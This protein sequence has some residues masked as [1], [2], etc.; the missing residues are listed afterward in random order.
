LN[1]VLGH[2]RAVMQEGSYLPTASILDPR[3]FP[4][5]NH[6]WTILD[7]NINI[8]AT[9]G[10]F[11]VSK[12]G[13]I[14]TG[15]KQD[16]LNAR[17]IPSADLSYFV[18]NFW[19]EL[20]TIEDGIDWRLDYEA[21]L[22][23]LWTLLSLEFMNG[24]ISS[25]VTR[26]GRNRFMMDLLAHIGHNESFSYTDS[27]TTSA[28]RMNELFE[29]DGIETVTATLMGYIPRFR[30]SQAARFTEASRV[31]G[32]EKFRTLLKTTPPEILNSEEDLKSFLEKI[33]RIAAYNPASLNREECIFVVNTYLAQQEEELGEV[34][35]EIFASLR[36]C[37]PGEISPGMV[38]EVFNRDPS[39][40]YQQ[41]AKVKI[42]NWAVRI[43]ERKARPIG[44]LD[45][46]LPIERTTCAF[47]AEAITAALNETLG[48]ARA[49]T[50]G[51]FYL[52]A[53]SEVDPG[54]FPNRNHAWT[55]LDGNINICATHG[56]FDVSKVGKILTGGKQKFL[57]ARLIPTA[58]LSYFVSDFWKEL[59]T[60][61]EDIS[62][63]LDHHTKLGLLWTLLSLEFMNE[64]I[65]SYVAIYGRNR[66]VMNLL[67]HIGYNESFSHAD[68]LK[69]SAVR[70]NEL[71]KSDGIETV[72]ATLM[73]YIPGFRENQAARFTE[74]NLLQ[75][76]KR[77]FHGMVGG[78]L[79]EDIG[80]L[81]NEK[82]SEVA[83]VLQ[84]TDGNIFRVFKRTGTQGI[85]GLHPSRVIKVSEEKLFNE[86]LINEAKVLHKLSGIPGIPRL[87]KIGPMR[88]GELWIELDGIE[89]ATSLELIYKFLTPSSVFEAFIKL[90]VILSV[91]HSRGFVHN[92]I[93]PSNVLRNK[94]G[95]VQ[96]NDFEIATP[97]GTKTFSGTPNFQPLNP[98]LTK[99]H[100]RDFDSDVYS[101]IMTLAEAL[102][103]IIKIPK[104][105]PKGL[106]ARLQKKYLRMIFEFGDFEQFIGGLEGE[107]V[108]VNAEGKLI[109]FK[110][111][112]RHQRPTL[113]ELIRELKKD[114]KIVKQAERTTS[115]FTERGSI[116]GLL[117]R[118]YTHETIIAGIPTTIVSRAGVDKAGI[119]LNRRELNIITPVF[120]ALAEFNRRH[121][122][123]GRQWHFEAM[124]ETGNRFYVQLG[125]M[126]SGRRWTREEL[127]NHIYIKA[128]DVNGPF[129]VAGRYLE[130]D[131]K[132]KKV[133]FK[134]PASRKPLNYTAERLPDACTEIARAIINRID[135][136]DTE[137]KM[138]SA[139]DQSRFT[140]TNTLREFKTHLD[141]LGNFRGT[142]SFKLDAN[143]LIMYTTSEL[144]MNAPDL[145][146]ALD[147]ISD[148][149]DTKDKKE[150]ILAVEVRDSK[151]SARVSQLLG[152]ANLP[153]N[154]TVHRVTR[155]F[156]ELKNPGIDLD[157]PSTRMQ[158][159]R[160]T[161][162][163][164]F[165]TSDN[166]VSAIALME[167]LPE[168]E[169]GEIHV[170]SF[171]Q[172][173]SDWLKAIERGERFSILP[174]LPLIL[175]A[176]AM[177]DLRLLLEEYLLQLE[178][179]S[180]V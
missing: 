127:A 110:P 143:R 126:F 78:M 84:S 1:E 23:L 70:M 57:N 177:G 68:S 179:D 92:D 82:S 43:L 103:W 172:V 10:Q 36:G 94:K 42:A 173:F 148:F 79:H 150:I 19:R 108:Y 25:Y 83:E 31:L 46:A 73:G 3:V 100:M 99:E 44:L 98:D 88:N 34:A 14:L 106:Y 64:E 147:M 71:F 55:V 38:E 131:G 174:V 63:E 8:C 124:I 86:Q 160:S 118:E 164:L 35:R 107:P 104:A 161:L 95:N 175:P 75:Q 115:R 165:G 67:A 29:S 117:E 133:T 65:S 166:T 81:Y 53:S 142:S 111:L 58:D 169:A 60:V 87:I 15:G 155:D 37:A 134:H 47:S 27:L 178:V 119:W 48:H 22:G 137:G 152:G 6:V 66:F 96:L 28:V 91:V 132:V 136:I 141:T 33:A 40:Y 80:F 171:A 130:L 180:K 89:N 112:E 52:F 50:Q 56:Q 138:L 69:T 144:L 20:I 93:T 97:R 30:E 54:T 85:T 156:I 168:V 21:R 90:A 74:G 11:D 24:E 26:Y 145:T 135:P 158:A 51:G 140:E 159:V 116:D 18:H 45:A 125:V 62:W 39:K 12:V 120:E 13:K 128:N 7:G 167:Q 17:L 163:T 109:C 170:I 61:V 72:T 149:A 5:V 114:F 123:E 151:D 32:V 154:L 129:E 101:F 2:A 121:T 139:T 76:L 102:N 59:T 157:E 77:K 105:E 4:S 113:D 122:Q 9:H 146:V 153:S 16:F 162:N 176:D 49:I 41:L